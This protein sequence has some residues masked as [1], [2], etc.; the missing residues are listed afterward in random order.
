MFKYISACFLAAVT[1]AQDKPVPAPNMKRMLDD[2]ARHYNDE[3]GVY[4]NY[5]YN[6]LIECMGKYNDTEL[7]QS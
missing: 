7:V 4:D 6:E 3:G 2:M 1:S 5:Y